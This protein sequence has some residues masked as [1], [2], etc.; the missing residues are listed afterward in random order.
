M[1]ELRISEEEREVLLAALRRIVPSD[2][3]HGVGDP[4]DRRRILVASELHDRIR[5]TT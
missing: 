4:A 2:F 3:P 1:S 5:T